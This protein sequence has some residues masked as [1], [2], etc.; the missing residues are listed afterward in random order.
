MHLLLQ[1]WSAYRHPKDWP[2]D[3]I[4]NG[5]DVSIVVHL[6]GQKTLRQLLSS[7]CEYYDLSPETQ[8][9]FNSLAYLQCFPREVQVFE[10][11]L[12]G[13]RIHKIFLL[14]R[15]ISWNACRTRMIQRH[16]L[17]FLFNDAMNTLMVQG[18]Q[19]PHVDLASIISRMVEWRKEK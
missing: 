4:R 18:T 8:D 17:Q 6:R 5:L 11:S 3:I 15:D 19:N 16:N 10:E 12:R 2:D 7:V 1:K 13:K 9:M 14:Q